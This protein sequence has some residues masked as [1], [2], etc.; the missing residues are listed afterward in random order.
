M[1]WRLPNLVDIAN[2]QLLMDRFFA[3]T[4]MPVAIVGSDGEIFIASGWQE[5]CTRFHRTSP[6]T[7]E[8]CRH[9][10]EFV[11]MCLPTEGYVHYKCMNGLWELAKPI[12]IAG[13]HLATLFLGQFF[14]DDEEIDEDF[15]ARQARECGFDLPSY[16]EVL[17]RIPTFSH[18]K[19]G[20]IMDFYAH[21]V[22][23]LVSMGVSSCQRAVAEQ[24]LRE[25]EQK[26][27]AAFHTAPTSM[28][29]STLVEGKFLEVNRSFESLYGYARDEVIGRTVDELDL[30]CDPWVRDDIVAELQ[31][32]GEVRDREIT[33]RDKSGDIH[34]GLFSGAI[35]T[36]NGEQQLLGLR[37][38]ITLRRKAEAALRTQFEEMCAIFDAIEAVLYVADLENHE[39]LYL[40]S[41]AESLFGTGWEGKKCFEIF[42]LGQTDPCS[43]CPNDRLVHVGRLQPPYVWE[44]LNTRTGQWYQCIDRAIT[45][46]DGR[47]VRLEIAFDISGRKRIED[48]LREAK[49]KFFKTFHSTPS[50][51]VISRLLDGRYLEVND[52]FEEVLGYSRQ[53]VIGRNALELG[54]WETPEE[55]GGFVQTVREE[56]KVRGFEAR[57]RSK[58][59]GIIVG[60]ISAEIIEIGKEECLLVL[61]SD[62]TGR[63]QMEEEIK[64]LN[65]ELL[66]RAAELEMANRELEAF[67]YTVSHDLR[68]PLTG[69]RGYCALL[70]ES[71]ISRFTDQDLVLLR[72]IESSAQRME[73]LI[74]TLLQFS[75][76]SRCTLI[77]E[78]VDLSGIFRKVT[79]RL[80]SADSDRAVVFHVTEEVTVQGDPKLLEI[81]IENLVGNAWKYSVNREVAHIE[82]GT[83][84]IAGNAVYFISD[85]GEGFDMKHADKLFR[86]F[87]R[88]AHTKHITGYGV[89]LATVQRII[90]RHGGKVWANA[91]PG[92]GATFY[93]TL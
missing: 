14:Y 27:A 37:S 68:S 40:N 51:L 63:K 61:I 76:L 16:L 78:S 19:V 92:G 15:F 42:Q 85:N 55:R 1:Q 69:I 4:A 20:Q 64:T 18:E 81:V 2:L 60:L 8:R 52:T 6:L 67:N 83:T 93:F 86:P 29:I 59:G 89:G 39:L 7:A 25:S 10:D 80:R 65:S 90:Q 58:G 82:F 9:S 57:L 84:E 11:K 38:D 73:R 47:L 79:A 12:V 71:D 5:A 32:G 31:A 48:E 87:E 34:L 91:K 35:I 66:S 3:A 46:R 22:T 50:I 56:R 17:R 28:S 43:F 53:E 45:W 77:R 26:F 75:R 33:L 54:L 88:M 49:D 23:F 74:N 24:A 30:W 41:Y 36:L 70:L 44:V 13:K 62:I 72:G 21:F